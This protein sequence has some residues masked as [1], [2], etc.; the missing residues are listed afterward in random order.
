MMA[1]RHHR[2]P[3]DGDLRGLGRDVSADD[4]AE[5]VRRRGSEW[6]TAKVESLMVRA[7]RTFDG[8]TWEANRTPNG[9]LRLQR[10][11]PLRAL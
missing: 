9:L 11:C 8:H 4:L 1:W 2:E 5:A 10:G 6:V 3:G 7:V